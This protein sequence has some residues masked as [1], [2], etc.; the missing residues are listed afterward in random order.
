[1]CN[2]IVWGLKDKLIA[3]MCNVIVW[4]LKDKQ[5]GFDTHY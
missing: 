3:N 4:G 5:I 1:M 2:V